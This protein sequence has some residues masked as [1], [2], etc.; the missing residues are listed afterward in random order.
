MRR[1]CRFGPDRSPVRRGSPG[2]AACREF[3]EG[4]ESTMRRD[5]QARANGLGGSD[6]PRAVVRGSRAG[7]W[8][9]QE[10]GESL[11]RSRVRTAATWRHGDRS[12]RWDSGREDPGTSC[13]PGR[14]ARDARP[15]D[16]G[17]ALHVPRIHPSPILIGETARTRPPRV[18]WCASR[19]NGTAAR[20]VDRA[21]TGSRRRTVPAVSPDRRPARSLGRAALLIRPAPPRATPRAAALHGRARCRR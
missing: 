10:S 1:Y 20:S 17:G 15:G 9:L 7:T 18:R 6:R 4:Q 13:D 21:S 11:S 14:H 8:G 5:I 12:A 19:T 2:H 3:P 16:A